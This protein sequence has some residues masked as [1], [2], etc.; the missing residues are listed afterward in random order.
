MYVNNIATSCEL[1]LY[2]GDTC[3]VFM[4]KD[5]KMIEEQLNKDLFIL[6]SVSFW[7]LLIIEYVARVSQHML[8]THD[9]LV[10]QV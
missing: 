9:L 7:P 4:G 5:T 1:L 2:A 6:A 10:E 8:F 3:P